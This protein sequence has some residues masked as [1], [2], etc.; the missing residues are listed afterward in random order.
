MSTRANAILGILL[1]IL[2]IVILW[3]LFV[4][5]RPERVDISVPKTE[6]KNEPVEAAP[7]GEIELPQQM[8][9]STPIVTPTV[10]SFEADR[11]AR[12]APRDIAL[13]NATNISEKREKAIAAREGKMDLSD[14]LSG[15]VTQAKLDSI[16]EFRRKKAEE[17]RR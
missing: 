1:V 10:V 9:E 16:R 8:P 12:V 4:A 15:G 3:F 7:E 17:E 5:G 11:E 13:Q 6:V 2:A 14:S